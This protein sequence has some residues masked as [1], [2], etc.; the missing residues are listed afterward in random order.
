MIFSKS[1]RQIFKIQSNLPPHIIFTY[2]LLKILIKSDKMM[3]TWNYLWFFF[4]FINWYNKNVNWRKTSKHCVYYRLELVEYYHICSSGSNK[5]NLIVANESI[6][7][8]G[9]H[10]YNMGI[11]LVDVSASLVM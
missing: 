1:K 10:I 2:T 7:W 6:W 11:N 4:K 8:K 5:S 3:V 9:K